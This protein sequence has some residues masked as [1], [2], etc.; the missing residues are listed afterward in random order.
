M[1]KTTTPLPSSMSLPPPTAL[2]AGPQIDDRETRNSPSAA[3][4]MERGGNWRDLQWA[5]LSAKELE[6]ATN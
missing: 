3:G 6:P 4:G 2:A 5:G 1:A